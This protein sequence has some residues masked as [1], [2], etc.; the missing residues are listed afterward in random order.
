MPANGPS[1]VAP[2]MHYTIPDYDRSG[3]IYS[4]NSS[5]RAISVTDVHAQ[6]AMYGYIGEE[7]T[8]FA[9][10]IL[11]VRPPLCDV[12][13]RPSGDGSL[14]YNGGVALYLSETSQESNESHVPLPLPSN[15]NQSAPFLYIS[16]NSSMHS[17]DH[18][19]PANGPS[20]IAPS[21]HYTIPN[22]DRSG[23]IYSQNSSGRAISVTDVHAQGAMYG[24][25]GEEGTP[26]AVNN[27]NFME[28]PMT[29]SDP[30]MDTFL[31]PDGS[32]AVSHAQVSPH[33]LDPVLFPM[34]DT[35]NSEAPNISIP[36]LNPRAEAVVKKEHNIVP[37]P[38]VC[39]AQ[40]CHTMLGDNS[41]I[42]KGVK[43]RPSKQVQKFI[44]VN[45]KEAFT[46]IKSAKRHE[47]HSEKVHQCSKCHGFSARKDQRIEHEKKCDGTLRQKKGR[48]AEFQLATIGN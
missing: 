6:G 28:Y 44:C 23:V 38:E 43:R 3:I 10:R 2:S 46:T 5:G 18:R 42:C 15:P 14:C 40:R 29:G 20:L 7:G 27:I 30:Q 25:I 4:Q 12:S 16:G 11:R 24:Y 39:I 33:T 17:N 8:P 48:Q 21:I 1:L 9:G 45:C 35:A 32:M 19:M 41:C 47:N 34:P 22:Y 36:P 31:G 37:L 13:D 26:F